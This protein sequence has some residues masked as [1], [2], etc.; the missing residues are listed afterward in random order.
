MATKKQ[1]IISKI[2]NDKSIQDYVNVFPNRVGSQG[3]DAWG[4]NIKNMKNNM[5]LT[6]YLVRRF[7]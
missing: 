1:N 2:F 6:K 3:F 5:R 4:F 7:L